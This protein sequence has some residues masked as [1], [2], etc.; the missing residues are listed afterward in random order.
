MTEIKWLNLMS[1]MGFDNNID[2][3]VQLLSSYN[4]KHH[5]YHNTQHINAVLKHL[6][7]AKH[8]SKDYD[9]VEIAL[10]FHDAKYNILSSS[11]ELDSAHWARNFLEKNGASEQLIHRVYTL[12][13]ATLHDVVAE[14]N[15]ETL[16]VDIDLSILGSEP[17]MFDRFESTMRKEYRMVPSLVYKKKRK[18]ILSGFLDRENIYSHSYFHQKL[19]ENARLNLSRAIQNL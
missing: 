15:D 5:H 11:N 10:W 8:L 14:D 17:S 12:I 13:M 18:A 19:E 4:E 1:R 7:E 3:Y 16:I 2:T 9:A 6:E